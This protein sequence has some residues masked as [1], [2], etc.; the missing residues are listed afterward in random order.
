MRPKP[1]AEVARLCSLLSENG[2]ST[3]SFTDDEENAWAWIYLKDVGGLLGTIEVAVMDIDIDLTQLLIRN[4]RWSKLIGNKAT[5]KAINVELKK[6]LT[7]N[8]WEYNAEIATVR[9]NGETFYLII[10]NGCLP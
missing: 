1:Y 10:A 3:V 2:I 8:V 6:R 7:A 5:I 9:L 4:P